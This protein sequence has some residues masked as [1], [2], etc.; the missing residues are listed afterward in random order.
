MVFCTCNL[1]LI[2]GGT[3]IVNFTLLFTGQ[4]GWRSGTLF[5]FLAENIPLEKTIGF[6]SPL[7]VDLVFLPA[8][9]ATGTEEQLGRLQESLCL[10]VPAK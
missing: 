3:S 8:Y 2:S 5:I 6:R 1:F 7:P 10:A 9:K 4:P